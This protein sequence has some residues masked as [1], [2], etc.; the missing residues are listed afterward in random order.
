MFV[1]LPLRGRLY[2]APDAIHRCLAVSEVPDVFV[3]RAELQHRLDG[4]E[5]CMMDGVRRAKPAWVDRNLAAAANIVH[6]CSDPGAAITPEVCPLPSVLW[7]WQGG[8]RTL[9]TIQR[10]DRPPFEMA[11]HR[12]TQKCCK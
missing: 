3:P 5:F 6:A 1:R 10:V 2:V 9:H 7:Q 11:Q 4:D 12:L 8:Q